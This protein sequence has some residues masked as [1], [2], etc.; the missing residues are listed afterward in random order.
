MTR[1][2]N[3]QEEEETIYMRKS[4]KLTG[5]RGKNEQEEEEGIRK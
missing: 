3:G 1:R 5:G 2:K 4:E